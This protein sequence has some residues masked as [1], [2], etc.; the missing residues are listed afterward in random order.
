MSGRDSSSEGSQGTTLGSCVPCISERGFPLFGSEELSWDIGLYMTISE[1]PTHFPRARTVITAMSVH[2]PD[3]LARERGQL[4][5]DS[6]NRMFGHN[7]ARELRLIDEVL[8]RTAFPG[9]SNA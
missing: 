7:A 1:G 8:S 5:F 3:Q 9:P 2:R 6:L 4:Q